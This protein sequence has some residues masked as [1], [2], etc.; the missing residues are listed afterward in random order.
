MTTPLKTRL[1]K[2][3]WATRFFKTRSLAAEAC[4]KGRVK[5]GEKALKP[6]YP[7][8]VDDLLI[9]RK[10]GLTQT[11]KVLDI[12]EKRVGAQVAAAFF[13]DLTS[14]EEYQKQKEYRENSILF[15]T[16]RKGRPTKKERRDIERLLE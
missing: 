3:L 1:D 2:W 5:M 16:T 7:V 10:E 6:G 4:R 13:E 14:P 8:K 15:R 12:L 9:L 11:I